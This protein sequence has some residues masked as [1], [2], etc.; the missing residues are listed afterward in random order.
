MKISH[1]RAAACCNSGNSS[2]L[3]SSGI[4]NI[5]MMLDVVDDEAINDLVFDIIRDC[6][7]NDAI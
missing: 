5:I 3:F 2:I 7:Y 6:L 4:E 1:P